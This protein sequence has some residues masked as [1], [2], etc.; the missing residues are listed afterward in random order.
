MV[1]M[2]PG[3]TCIGCCF[4]KQVECTFP[5]PSEKECERGFIYKKT[6]DEHIEVKDNGQGMNIPVPVS[7][8]YET[9]WRCG[10]IVHNLDVPFKDLIIESPAT[11]SVTKLG[12]DLNKCRIAT[13]MDGREVYG[14]VKIT[15]KGTKVEDTKINLCDT[16]KF[17]VP[18][19]R[20]LFEDLKFGDGTGND[21]VIKCDEYQN[22]ETIRHSE[23]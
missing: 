19:C 2:I 12:D 22:E 23:S 6:Y 5:T 14:R 11:T 13:P 8:E 15:R 17:T 9:Y 7:W 10:D 1:K 18:E 16:C 3:K 20:P 4:N 21:N